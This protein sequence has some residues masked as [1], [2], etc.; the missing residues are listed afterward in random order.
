MQQLTAHNV[1]TP[2]VLAVGAALTILLGGC[3]RDANRTADG[4][5][6]AKPISIEEIRLLNVDDQTIAPLANSLDPATVFLFV[7]TD[8]PIS[9]R[10]APTFNRLVDQFQPQGVTFY[11]VYPNPTLD[12]QSV[13]AHLQEYSYRCAGLRDPDHDLVRLTNAEVTPEAVVFD[14]TRTIAYRGR[15][16]D[17][18]VDFGKARSEPTSHDLAD[19]LTAVLAGE[20]VAEPVTKAVGCYI[21]DLRASQSP[22]ASPDSNN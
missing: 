3:G 22:S 10:L 19:A 14:A 17:L 18:Y 8:C 1:N 6:A 15:I 9:N 11:L 16:N 2:V 13:K 4:Q 5:S 20:Q 12:G 7:R 21:G